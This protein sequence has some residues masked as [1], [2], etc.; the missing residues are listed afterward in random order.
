MNV[1][2]MRG[3][4][5]EEGL[6]TIA[7]LYGPFNA[8]YSD[9]AL[10]RELFNGNPH[11]N[12]VH[13]FATEDGKRVGHYAL[14][15]REIVVQGER[16]LSGKG[17]A[18][19]VHERYRDR[20]VSSGNAPM[21]AGM[22]LPLA[23]YRHGLDHGIDPIHMIAEPAVGLLHRMTG[24]RAVAADHRRWRL[25]LDPAT[26]IEATGSPTRALALRAL[27]V[28]QRVAFEV[29]AFPSAATRTW[30]GADLRPD[31]LD[32]VAAALP[33]IPGW[34]LQVDAPTLA[35]FAR[36]GALT[37]VAN[38]DDMRNHAIL[39]ARR[40]DARRS[41]ELILWRLQEPKSSAAV[42]LL[43]AVVREAVRAGAGSVTVSEN[44]AW[45]PG[46]RAVLRA[47]AR[48]LA[49]HERIQ[50]AQLF[51]RTNDKYFVEPGHLVLTPFFYAAF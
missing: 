47:A 22:A 16:R 51:V 15:P 33:A 39:Y 1:E 24:C 48:R 8:R 45:T 37:V 36:L 10:V 40:G 43:A 26:M 11:G 44:A 4:L 5:D 30:S 21:P 23:L 41:A 9:P 17:E 50:A 49:F 35:W 31:R 6:R 13:A 34:T 46:E 14:V 20:L 2:V 42:R 32:R 3:P 27:A 7:D 25:V 29:S 18:F 38:G 28:V 12:S 19:A